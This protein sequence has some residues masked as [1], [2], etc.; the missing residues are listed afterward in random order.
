MSVVQVETQTSRL[1]STVLPTHE[2]EMEKWGGEGRGKE[3]RGEERRGEGR[4]GE[5]KGEER[6]GEERRGEERREV[7]RVKE[8][9]HK[10]VHVVKLSTKVNTSR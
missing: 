6:R 5:G 1:D 8:G 9:K 10:Q 7:R 2:E 3:R 4:G